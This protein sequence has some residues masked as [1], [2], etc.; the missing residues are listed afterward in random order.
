MTSEVPL[1]VVIRIPYKRPAGFVDPPSVIWTEEMEQKLWEIL[2][3]NKRSNIDWNAASRLLNVPVPYLLRYAAFLYETQLRGV[4][5]Q[6]RLGEAMSSSGTLSSRNRAPSLNTGY[7]RPTSALSNNS[8]EHYM[9]SRGVSVGSQE[10]IRNGSNTSLSDGRKP[11]N[12]STSSSITAS[13]T[14]E[15]GI[16]SQSKTSLLSFENKPSVTPSPTQIGSSTLPRKTMSA[17]SSVSTITTIDLIPKQTTQFNQFT[18]VTQ[19]TQAIQS[20]SENLTSLES[21]SNSFMTPAASL[22]LSP[23]IHLSDENQETSKN[24]I[25]HSVYLENNYSDL[26]RD[27]ESD[28]VN[29]N[30]LSVRLAELTKQSV[31]AF[32]PSVSIPDDD[33]K[34]NLREVT[35]IL[36]PIKT[37]V[38]IIDNLRN[39]IKSDSSSSNLGLQPT[40][41]Q[42][43]AA[44]SQ[45][46]LS[47]N[48]S[49]NSSSSLSDI[50]SL[51]QSEL[52]NAYLE[53]TN[54][55]NSKIKSSHY[56]GPITNSNIL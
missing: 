41:K 49:A 22:S 3:S 47:A 26:I 56:P 42:I 12:G 31:A 27:D 32:L 52:E 34:S 53:D 33:V 44:D 35:E 45:Q 54:F 23:G 14:N 51:T 46:S 24:S 4:Q 5:M 25:I 55:N 10:M 37:K 6:L 15:I 29:D 9:T 11:T 19:A 43:P 38:P 39:I 18:Q 28:N 21:S 13:V 17:S 1:H 20:K 50:D 8:R 30:S 2:T 7:Q 40:N 16:S 48:D 36:D